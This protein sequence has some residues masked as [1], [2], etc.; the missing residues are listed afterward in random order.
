MQWL[1]KSTQH[2]VLGSLS[3]LMLF[4]SVAL[5]VVSRIADEK[6]SEMN[7]GFLFIGMIGI[8]AHQAI[9]DVFKRIER[10]EKRQEEST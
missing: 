8:A 1:G 2:R 7:F 5:S 3:L 9:G 10:L 6:N 4:M